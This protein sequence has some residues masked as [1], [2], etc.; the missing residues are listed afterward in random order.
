MRPLHGLNIGKD[1]TM[2]RKQAKLWE[3]YE[4]GTSLDAIWT[5]CGYK[6]RDECLKDLRSLRWDHWKKTGEKK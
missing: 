1:Y 2:T 3:E 4:N 6:T 5:K